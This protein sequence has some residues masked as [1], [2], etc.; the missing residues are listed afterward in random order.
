[1]MSEAT[2]PGA[3]GVTL[4]LPFDVQRPLS[5]RNK[6]TLFPCLFPLP[7]RRV[8]WITTLQYSVIKRT[9]ASCARLRAGTRIGHP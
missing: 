9:L 4:M 6:A 1:M 7:P 3:K 5:A 2:K 8:L